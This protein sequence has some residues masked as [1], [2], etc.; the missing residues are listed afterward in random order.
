MKVNLSTILLNDFKETYRDAKA[1]TL[2]GQGLNARG[3]HVSRTFTLSGDAIIEAEKEIG[4][5][6]AFRKVSKSSLS[7]LV[8]LVPEGSEL[9]VDL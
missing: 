4:R 9:V 6:C 2:C 7:A 8:N 5:E 1:R 3:L